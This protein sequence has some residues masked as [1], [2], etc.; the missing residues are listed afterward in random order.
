M[1]LGKRI[2]PSTISTNASTQKSIVMSVI[3][4]ISFLSIIE[5]CHTRLGWPII[6][7][8]KPGNCIIRSILQYKKSFTPGILYIPAPSLYTRLT[9][10]SRS[11]PL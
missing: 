5:Y 3:K 2:H 6:I 4:S 8:P 10:R 7:G 1:Q 9:T 11:S